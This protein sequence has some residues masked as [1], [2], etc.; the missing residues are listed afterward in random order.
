MDRR[1]FEQELSN[2][3]Q[4]EVQGL[5]PGEKVALVHRHLDQLALTPAHERLAIAFEPFVPGRRPIDEAAFPGLGSS[6][7]VALF[8]RGR[9]DDD[10][11]TFLLR[12]RRGGRLT[13]GL[14]AGARLL[15]TL[16]TL[17][18]EGRPS[19]VLPAWDRRDLAAFLTRLP[20]R[21]APEQAATF[22]LQLDIERTFAAPPPPIAPAD[23]LGFASQFHQ[24]LRLVVEVE[25][26]GLQVAAAS[27]RFEIHNEELYG[28]LYQRLVDRLL[29]WDTARQAFAV[30]HAVPPVA[31]H[32][33]FPVLCI[34]M[35]KARLYMQAV[36]G[37]LVEEKRMLTDPGW[38]LRV[39]LYLE[40]LTCL[41]VCEAVSGEI[42]LL[43]PQERAVLTQSPQYAEIRRRLDPVA[44]QEV[45]KLREIAW[46]LGQ[47]PTGARNLMRKK[48]ATLAFLHA[49][50]EDLKHAIELAG[51]NLHN[52]Q[53]TW[54]RVFRDAERAVLTMNAEAF[55]ELAELHPSLRELALWHESGTFGGRRLAPRRLSEL[56]GDQDG[57]F[58]SACRQ[59]RAS[60]NEIAGWARERGLMEYTG[61]ECVP[62]AAS[63]LEA[64]LAGQSGR[65]AA[66]QR[67]DGYA[68]T[69]QVLTAVER[70]PEISLEAI[71]TCLERVELFSALSA[72]ELRTLAAELRPIQLGPLE[73][74]L[75][76]GRPG[77]SLFLLQQG[78]LEVL[79]K[80][81]R[82]ERQ[83][84]LL[85]PPA[86]VGELS[87][88]TGEKRSATVRAVDGATVLEVAASC[89]RPLVEQRPALLDRLH[90]LLTARRQQNEER[91]VAPDRLLD[92]V[93]R[94]IFGRPSPGPRPTPA[95]G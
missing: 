33:W 2:L 89:L 38:L 84:A 4:A 5:S 75:L 49:H 85:G 64:H 73:R 90:A 6:E 32:P 16:E 28:S 35:Q 21:S 66:L 47:A 80:Q 65:L 24:A 52:A 44:W 1:T 61:D 77:N 36:V 83:I 71:V 81:G 37:D 50:H 87:F 59:Y 95:H 25:I 82:S 27:H 3:L 46:G 63:L 54:H 11:I 14:P 72:D 67:R 8:H 15:G 94:A 29:P 39:G 60:M 70:Q 42:D 18:A 45:W 12:C 56:V 68:A 30:G 40:L 93:R 10:H 74:I 62:I 78:S 92:G 19:A 31:V 7:V 53:E 23:W 76:E 9:K 51:P 48:A 13:A 20:G 88:L 26:D 57:I 69:L 22:A 41:G 79:R 17:D 34:G 91:Q 58:A 55:P 43:T 86:V